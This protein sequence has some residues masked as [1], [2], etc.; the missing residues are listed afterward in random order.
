[1]AATEVPATQSMMDE[2][3]IVIKVSSA[4]W[5]LVGLEWVSDVSLLVCRDHDSALYFLDFETN[6]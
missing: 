2:V 1:M 3:L 4:D 5:A 6:D